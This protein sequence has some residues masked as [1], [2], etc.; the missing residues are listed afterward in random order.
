MKVRPVHL[1]HS[2]IVLAVLIQLGFAA[3]FLA[4]AVG[5]NR[6]YNALVAHHVTVPAQAGLCSG[7]RPGRYHLTTR[8]PSLCAVEYS[9]AGRTYHDVV[10]NSDPREFVIDPQNVS[11]R[12][13]EAAFRNGPVE[14]IGD[15][16]FAS[17]LLAGALSMTT[18]HQIHLRRRRK[19]GRT[20]RLAPGPA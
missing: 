14:K 4:D 19:A 3:A 12:M 13:S 5:A 20:V 7:N 2:G 17:L 18:V 9:Y 8:S 11:Y 1:L 6:T 15:L 10:G 16:V